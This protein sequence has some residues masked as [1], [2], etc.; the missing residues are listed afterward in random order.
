[1]SIAPTDAATEAPPEKPAIDPRLRLRRTAVLRHQGRRRLR[2]VVVVAAV[3]FVALAALLTLHSS[4]LSARHV[5][6]RGARHT[7]LGSVLAVSGLA[8]HPPLIDIDPAAVAR[9][10]DRLAWVDRAVVSR[11]WPDSVT[12]T[13]TERTPVAAVDV[14]AAVVLVDGS[15]RVLAWGSSRPDL[16][17]LIAPGRPGAPGS[18]LGRTY[19]PGLAAL[20]SVP[21][22]LRGRILDVTVAGNGDVTLGFPGDVTAAFGPADD[23][24]AKYEALASVLSGAPP[25]GPE[26]IEVAVPDAPVVAP[27]VVVAPRH[28]PTP[29]ATPPPTPAATP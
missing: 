28:P 19:Q 4:L 6:V 3:V 24:A 18:S 25:S 27:V 15:G 2:L 1:M 16:P 11:H 22:A 9:Q 21:S 26:V 10:V 14:G 29:P 8:A 7:S 13:I 20:G 5:T 23:L 17:Q 12:M